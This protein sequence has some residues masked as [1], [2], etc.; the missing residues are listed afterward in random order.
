MSDYPRSIAYRVMVLF[1]YCVL[2]VFD[3]VFC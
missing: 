3:L 2:R 1:R